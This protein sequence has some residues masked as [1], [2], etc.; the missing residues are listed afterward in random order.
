[1]ETTPHHPAAIAAPGWGLR[2][3]RVTGRLRH[4]PLLL[5]PRRG[6]ARRWLYVAAGGVA[7][8]GTPVVAGAAIVRLAPVVVAFAYA[9]VGSRTVTF[10]ARAP[11]AA[12]RNVGSDATA[13]ARFRRGSAQLE[14][15]GDGGLRIEVPTTD[16][17]LSVHADTVTDVLPVVLVTAT[18]DGGWNVTEK[19]AGTAARLEVAVDGHRVEVPRAAGWRDY[20]AGRQD[21]RTRWRWAAGAGYAADGTRIG[22]NASTGMNGAAEGED[23][24]WI[25]GVPRPMEVQDLAP[26]DP[27]APS[28][29]WRVRGPGTALEL[30]PLGER[31]RREQLGPVVSDYTQPIGRWRGRAA[32]RGGTAVEVDLVG[33]AE[34]HLAVW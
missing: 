31:S 8:D 13:G 18:P 30:A 29:T 10:D 14:L 15:T 4:D 5:G 2:F 32:V 17:H 34:D 1:M 27:A 12:G 21:R 7:T 6:R 16:G 22:M 24:L 33:V 3:G 9:T 26:V 23:L 20:T 25:D 28:G 11:L 19:A